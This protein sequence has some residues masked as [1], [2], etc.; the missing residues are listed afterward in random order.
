[1]LL[2][3][4]GLARAHQTGDVNC[5]GAINAFDIDPFVLALTDPVAYAAEYPAATSC[6]PM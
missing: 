3:G 1:M 4:P 5:D 6:L 2:A